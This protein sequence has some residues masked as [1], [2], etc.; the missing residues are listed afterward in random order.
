MPDKPSAD[1]GS[2]ATTSISFMEA[3]RRNRSGAL[4]AGLVVMVVTALVLSAAVPND[5]NTATSILL[6]LLLAAAIGFAVKATSPAID[7]PTLA[8]AGGLALVGVPFMLVAG[9]A[10]ESFDGAML[11]ALGSEFLTVEAVLGAAIAVVV[12]AWGDRPK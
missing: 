7:A 11:A 1:R 6:I 2:R 10:G 9:T 5:L 12:A 4:L 3:L 8:T